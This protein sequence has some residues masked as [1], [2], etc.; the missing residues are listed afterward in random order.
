MVLLQRVRITNRRKQPRTVSVAMNHRRH[1]AGAGAAKVEVQRRGGAWV[2]QETAAQRA[3]FAVEG[4]DLAVTSCQ[5]LPRR[6]SA[7]G[8]NG[9]SL[10]CRTIVSLSLPAGASRR[11]VVKLPSPLVPRDRQGRLRP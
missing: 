9:E 2:F 5:T 8:R 11:F 3:L 1:F 6:S 10:A 7:K 4:T